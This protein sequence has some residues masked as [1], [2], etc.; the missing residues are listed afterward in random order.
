MAHGTEND[1]IKFSDGEKYKLR[2]LL[3]PLLM[4]RNLNGKPKIVVT[5]FCRGISQLAGQIR[6]PESDEEV[7]TDGDTQIRVND[8][9]RITFIFSTLVMNALK[10]RI[11]LIIFFKLDMVICYATAPGNLAIRS[12][13]GSHFI[14]LF[15][16]FLRKN[17]SIESI[18]KRVTKQICHKDYQIEHDGDIVKVRIAPQMESTL[19]KNLIF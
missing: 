1:E 12:T 10:D 13:S 17:A 7:F 6:E 15:G 14:K 11:I 2:K 19:R 5:Q 4:C 8:Q 16:K 18:M 3:R 9:V